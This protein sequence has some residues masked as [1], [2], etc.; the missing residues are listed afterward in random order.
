MNCAQARFLLYAYLDRDPSR[1]ESEALARHLAHCPSC[2]ARSR[3]ARGLAKLLRSRLDRTP[4]PSRL[5]IRLQQRVPLEVRPRYA[6]FWMAAA[7]VLLI[8]PTV[9]SV[10]GP[11][12]LGLS[13]ASA[14]APATVPTV[15][16]ITALSRPSAAAVSR[17]V[18]GTLVCIDCEARHEAGLCPLPHAHHEAGLCTE[19]G[20]VWLLMSRDPGFLREAAGQTLTVE[21]VAFP[22]SGFLRASRVGY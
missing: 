19:D 1:W 9:A 10:P 7:V 3:S 22:R 17:R 15:S 13:A 4:A 8:V 16:A 11:R 12:P 2:E 20:E 14:S 21:G 6:G 18:T 5:R